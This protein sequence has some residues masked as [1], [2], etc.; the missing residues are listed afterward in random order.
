MNRIHIYADGSCMNIND[1]SRAGW[2]IVIVHGDDGLGRGRGTISEEFY[3]LVQIDPG[4]DD[5]KGA[6]LA[7][8]NTAELTAL[9][10]GLRWVNQYDGGEE[11]TIRCDSMYAIEIAEGRWKAKANLELVDVV[12]A[13]LSAARVG[14]GVELNHV[15]GHEG[16]R[17][18]ERAD[19]LARSA[20]EGKKPKGLSFW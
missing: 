18:N 6:L 13:A 17:W 8:N 9:L 15:R 4:S 12:R 16:H 10:E 3:G 11:I 19:H 20:A 5:W 7:S 1:E 2:G 14:R